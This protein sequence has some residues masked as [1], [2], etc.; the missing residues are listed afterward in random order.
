MKIF[1]L[2]I[3]GFIGNA[4]ARR[5]VASQK[6]E[7]SGVDINSYN[8]EDLKKKKNF[9]FYKLDV[10]KA[11]NKIENILK[12]SDVVIPL[13]AIATPNVYVKDPLRIFR[14]DFESNLEIIKLCAKYRKRIIFP[15]TS[16]VYGMCNDKY[17]DEKK[18]KFILGPI[19]K[20]RWIYS[21]SKQLL[22]RVILAFTEQK[23]IKSTI[24]RPFNWIGP[25]LDSLKE[26]QLGNGRVLSIF[27]NNILRNKNLHLVNGG[28]QSRSLTYIDDGIDALEKIIFS[29]SKKINGEIFNIGNP[30]NNISI[31]DL[32]SKII[33]IYNLKSNKKYKGKIVTKTEKEF[34]GSGYQDIEF[35]LPSISNAKNKLKWSPKNNLNNSLNKTLDYYLDKND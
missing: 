14:L 29:D 35:R 16:E 20:P 1:I 23:S 13:V 22:D 26:A 24:F 10:F 12:K 3:N 27:I 28:N 11:Q 15:S 33:Y 25:K 8:I 4:L 31:K 6:V 30:K 17:F 19:N 21:C 32:A 34:Y 5:L 2:G 7:V 18:S 9:F